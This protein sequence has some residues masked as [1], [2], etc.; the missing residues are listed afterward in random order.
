[1]DLVVVEYVLLSKDKVFK[2]LSLNKLHPS[3]QSR[4]GY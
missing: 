3:K 1:M 4:N 2:Y